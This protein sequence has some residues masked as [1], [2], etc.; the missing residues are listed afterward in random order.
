M[1]KNRMAHASKSDK[2]VI[3]K[4]HTVLSNTAQAVLTEQGQNTND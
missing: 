2:T 4:T 1:K 3:E